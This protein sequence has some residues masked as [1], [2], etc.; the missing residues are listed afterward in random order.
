MFD[1][2]LNVDCAYGRTSAFSDYCRLLD[3]SKRTFFKC[4]NRLFQAFAE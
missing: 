3:R 4:D 2:L 1:L